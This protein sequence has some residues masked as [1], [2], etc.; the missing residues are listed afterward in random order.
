MGTGIEAIAPVI[1][2]VGSTAS[3]ANS[4]FGNKSN[5]GAA[6]AQAQLQESRNAREYQAALNAELMRRATSGYTDA[7]G[8]SLTYDPTTN[9]WTSKL[10]PTQ[11]TAY[12]SMLHAISD[13]NVKGVADVNRANDL[14]TGRAIEGNATAHG[15][16]N[17]YNNY[18]DI[19]PEDIRSTL[20]N[21]IINAN[22]RTTQPIVQD[23][24]RQFT[25]TGQTAGPALARLASDSYD[26]IKQGIADASI[27]SIKTASDIN[28]GNRGSILRDW[29]SLVQGSTPQLQQTNPANYDPT[30]VMTN[31]LMSRANN[32]AA[33]G[34]A[35]TYGNVATAGNVNSSYAPLYATQPNPQQGSLNI[36]GI[37]DQ[38]ANLV[39]KGS[40]AYDY[41]FPKPDTKDT[42]NLKTGTIEFG[43]QYN[44]D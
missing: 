32:S 42:S 19:T 23:T 31:L 39:K 5:P 27:G 40:S 1:S 17:R 29:T 14:V 6:I 22:N 34:Q 3:A 30:S 33:A 12:N 20:I 24:M 7:G 8:G 15:V 18:V 10:G 38:L 44:Y 37:G 2:A 11:Q 41:F 16:L 13:K 25:R 36:L 26:R 21:S 43:S 35:A 4:L 28:A 9:S